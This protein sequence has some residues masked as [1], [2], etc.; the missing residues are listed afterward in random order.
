MEVEIIP[1]V[2]DEEHKKYVYLKIFIVPSSF[3]HLSEE[4]KN[5]TFSGYVS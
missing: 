4:L 1:H 2:K 3:F 5:F